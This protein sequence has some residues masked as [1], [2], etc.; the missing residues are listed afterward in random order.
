MDSIKT[1]FQTKAEIYK[2]V[3][4]GKA[5]L[6]PMTSYIISLK[7]SIALLY[8]ETTNDQLK[9]VII[10]LYRKLEEFK[11]H[12]DDISGVN[13]NSSKKIYD[14]LQLIEKSSTTCTIN[15]N[16][17]KAC[18]GSV[19]DTDNIRIMFTDLEHGI[20]MKESE[21]K[22]IVMMNNII[23]QLTKQIHSDNLAYESLKIEV[24]TK[25]ITDSLTNVVNNT[26]ANQ[27]LSQIQTP[28]LHKA[29]TA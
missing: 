28:D 24:L 27:I 26:C 3:L 13:L 12:T 22:L 25:S 8:Q 11:V 6:N 16:P 14:I 29:L 20:V 7:H 17:Y 10:S 2:L 15:Y 9:E 19:L 5:F 4:S 1:P 18:L 23:E 21:D